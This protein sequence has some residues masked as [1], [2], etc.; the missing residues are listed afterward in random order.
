M[1]EVDANLW[2]QQFQAAWFGLLMH[3][4]SELGQSWVLT[5]LVIVIAFALRLR[6]GLGLMLALVLAG[7]ATDTIKSGAGLPRPSEVDA[8]VLDKGRSGKHLVADG[9]ADGFWALPAGQGIEAKRATGEGDYGFISGHVSAA[10]A[11]AFSLA[12]M[13]G[14]R[15]WGWW[16][17]ALAWPMLMALSRLYL[18]RHFLADVLGGLLFGAAAAALA[19]AFLRAAEPGQRLAGPSWQ[20]AA[21]L[22]AA[23]A[24]LA[25]A[26][27]PLDIYQAGSLGGVLLCIAWV[28]A[29]KVPDAAQ[30]A[31]RRIGS[32]VIALMFVIATSAGLDALHGLGGWPDGHIAG[33]LFALVGYPLAM[34]GALCVLQWLRLYPRPDGRGETP[35][36]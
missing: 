6:P 23:L 29:H 2:L 33:A 34:V 31:W 36:R 3:W 1:F 32:A 25:M 13:F 9:A 30:G 21:G 15:R 20:V 5:P 17:L 4:M 14:A 19:W 26:W 27:P 24:L 8:R 12:L 7:M 22:V 16:L 10:A 35:V 28:L 18:G 11:L